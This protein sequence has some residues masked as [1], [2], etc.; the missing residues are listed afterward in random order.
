LRGVERG[1]RS[2]PRSEDRLEHWARQRRRGRE[3]GRTSDP[4]DSRGSG[5]GPGL[6]APALRTMVESSRVSVSQKTRSVGGFRARR[7]RE[8]VTGPAG[9]SPSRRR[10]LGPRG[11]G[12]SCGKASAAH[13]G[14]QRNMVALDGIWLEHRDRGVWRGRREG[15][16]RCPPREDRLEHWA[17]KVGGAPVGLRSAEPQRPPPP[18]RL[19][20]SHV[21]H[22]ASRQDPS[23]PSAPVG[24]RHD[25]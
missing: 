17:P 15:A 7:A 18:H 1:Q 14:A 8:R 23:A 21:Q 5:Y 16:M 11:V 19:I 25:P 20:R 4:G 12:E 2:P 3:W 10:G 22:G 24:S 13:R 9:S 6:G